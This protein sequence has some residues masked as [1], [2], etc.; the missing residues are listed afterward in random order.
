MRLNAMASAATRASQ[1][2][3]GKAPVH[4]LRPACTWDKGLCFRR[5]VASQCDVQIEKSYPAA[6]SEGTAS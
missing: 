3:T 4:G 6:L 5:V 1:C 2:W